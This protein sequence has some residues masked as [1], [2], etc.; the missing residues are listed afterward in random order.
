MAIVIIAWLVSMSILIIGTVF[1]AV[2][3]LMAK[4]DKILKELLDE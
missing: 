4:L 1:I 3:L 2:N